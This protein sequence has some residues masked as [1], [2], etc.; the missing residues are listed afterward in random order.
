VPEFTRSELDKLGDRLRGDNYTEEDLAKLD[1]Y[2]T[3]VLFAT[4]PFGQWIRDA[5]ETKTIDVYSYF[6]RTQKN[7]AIIRAKLRREH[8]EL[9]TMQDIAGCR[10]VFQ[11]ILHLNEAWSQIVQKFADVKVIDRLSVPRNGYRAVH[12]IYRTDIYSYE[13]QLRTRLQHAWAEISEKL[14]DKYGLELKYG[15]GPVPVR[16]FL[17][18]FSDNIASFEEVEDEQLLEYAGSASFNTDPEGLE[19]SPDLRRKREELILKMQDEF[20][21]FV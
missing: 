19:G 14:A 7:N 11:T 17:L 8:T 9:P 15:G 18:R 5:V 2:K 12:I 21:R 3:A 16:D 10:L 1:R 4:R 13:V 6:A 20:Q